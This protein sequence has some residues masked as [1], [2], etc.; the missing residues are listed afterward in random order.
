MTMDKM[1][2]IGF[3]HGGKFSR[4]NQQEKPMNSSFFQDT[5][6]IRFSVTGTFTLALA[7]D[8]IAQGK[9]KLSL[10]FLRETEWYYIL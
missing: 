4:G 1:S 7:V 9:N 8:R 6:C 5:Q 3:S 10:A 2:K